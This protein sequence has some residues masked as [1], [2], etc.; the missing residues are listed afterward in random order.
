VDAI[1]SG[2]F[3]GLYATRLLQRG[4]HLA[5]YRAFGT[6]SLC[7]VDGGAYFSFG[8][9][10][11][12]RRAVKKALQFSHQ[13]AIV[14]PKL[15]DRNRCAKRRITKLPF[16]IADGLYSKQPMPALCVCCQT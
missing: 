7:V 9:P 6:Y 8:C 4:K 13:A 2:A 11:C 16:T 10:S 15:S 12:R 3:E 1:D 14:H 5:P